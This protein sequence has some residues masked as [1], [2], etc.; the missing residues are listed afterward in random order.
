MC[1]IAGFYSHDFAGGAAKKKSVLQGMGMAIAHRGPDNGD[2]WTGDHSGDPAFVHRRLSILDL[3]PE[4]HQPMVSASGR[5]IMVYNGEIYNFKE[6]R[7]ELESAGQ[8]FRGRSDTEVFLAACDQ[9]GLNR[10]L[11]K[12][13]GMF[14]FALWDK[15]GREL[16]FARDRMGKKPLYVGWADNGLVF[17]SELKAVRAYPDF[18]AEMDMGAAASYF[19]YGFIP[20][21]ACIYKNMWQ[22]PAG[23]RLSVSDDV[24]QK[25]TDLS[26]L[27]KPYWHHVRQ[28]EEARTHS[29]LDDLESAIDGLEN[30]IEQ[31]V[32]ERMIS[33]V[34]L[35]AFLSGG[36][37]SSVVT[38][39]MQKNSL[40]KVKTY[41][42]GFEENDYNEALYARDVAKHLGTDHHEQI[43]TA[44]DAL[45]I[46]PD[47]AGIYDEPFS[48]ISALP[49]LLLSRFTR[50]DVTVAL[51]GD[52]GDEMLGGYRRHIMA[53]ALWPKLRVMPHMLRYCGANIL[54]ALP[55]SMR[56]HIPALPRDDYNFSKALEVL[57]AKDEQDLY[58]RL[59][60][61]NKNP[62][63]IL[64]C[65]FSETRT[66]L[67][68]S[69]WALPDDMASAE[70]MMAWDMINYL[71]GDILT[72]V[73]RA[74]MASSLEVRAPLLDKAVFD[75][76]WRLPL[77]YKIVPSPGM[78]SSF[79]Y[80]GKYLLREVLKRHIPQDLY[81]R[82]KQGFS[83]PV[84]SWLRGPLKDWAQNLLDESNIKHD[85]L[86]DYQRISKMW[87]NHLNGSDNHAIQLW[88]LLMFLSWKE[89][90]L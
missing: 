4:G 77:N 65:D 9:W 63:E 66:P 55:S 13:T 18:T 70:K 57:K 1:G 27:M 33:D 6:L 14:A 78:G 90:W 53:Q 41:T 31:A 88:S 8:V 87:N 83:I 82:P 30:V 72:K 35:G 85:G 84:G 45:D 47:L 73:D 20:S 12:I 69:D 50:R 43:L 15:Q 86:L 19:R 37:D 51:S 7:A 11:Q 49:T 75:Y 21:P 38:A 29:A 34:P 3:S 52:G 28:L 39:F 64:S 67:T 40:S 5:Y 54:A 25:R 23:F 24:I 74:S 61:L 42:I 2:V 79:G 48:D 10:S 58:G 17:G 44:R 89:R 16:H 22:I 46:I 26:S 81:E 71:P 32:K 76:A 56:R 59:I 62:A 36:I 80:Q 60:C 68:H